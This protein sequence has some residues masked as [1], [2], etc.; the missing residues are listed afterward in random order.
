MKFS[1]QYDK[2]DPLV[3]VTLSPQ[4]DLGEIL[5]AFQGFLQAAGYCFKP[6]EVIDIVDNTPVDVPIE[7]ALPDE[8]N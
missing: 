4:S 7:D 3:E 5:T 6:N 8:V 1:Y 2:H